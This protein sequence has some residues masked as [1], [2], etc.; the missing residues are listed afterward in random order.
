MARPTLAQLRDAFALYVRGDAADLTAALLAGR[1]PID[2]T[3]LALPVEGFA[4]GVPVRV[5]GASGGVAV[6]VSAGVTRTSGALLAAVAAPAA[7]DINVD[8]TI[9]GDYTRIALAARLS[10]IDAQGDLTLSAR[11]YEPDGVTLNHSPI[12]SAIGDTLIGNVAYAD[13]TLNTY[14]RAKWQMRV[15]NNDA[16]AAGTATLAYYLETG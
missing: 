15:R 10:G 1:N 8:F 4:S 3:P 7:S 6:P 12:A 14:G 9:P 13:T 11:V 2:D 5:E 16:L